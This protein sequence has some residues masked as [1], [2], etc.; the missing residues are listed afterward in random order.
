MVVVYRQGQVQRRE[1]LDDVEHPPPRSRVSISSTS[2]FRTGGKVSLM[3]CP[4]WWNCSAPS[5]GVLPAPVEPE[6]EIVQDRLGLGENPEAVRVAAD[7]LSRPFDSAF[8]WRGPPIEQPPTFLAARVAGGRKQ[9][10]DPGALRE[11]A[12]L[13]R[14][15]VRL[16]PPPELDGPDVT[17]AV[18]RPP[19]LGTQGEPIGDAAHGTEKKLAAWT[20][21][22]PLP[23]GSQKVEHER[24]VRN[25]VRRFGRERSLAVPRH[26]EP[27][28]RLVDAK[29]RDRSR[30][31]PAGDA[32]QE[33]RVVFLCGC[34]DQDRYGAQNPTILRRP[35]G[36][37]ERAT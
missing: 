21:L 35:G 24:A 23:L 6:E 37:A 32:V 4:P 13:Q 2:K 11:E 29:K 1:V 14:G 8:G 15:D 28:D 17:L 12:C 7:R 34:V 20:C 9:R 3:S 26:L 22:S 18:K 27:P 30:S 19:M 5:L 33:D 36:A 31:R 16:I 25:G 10:A